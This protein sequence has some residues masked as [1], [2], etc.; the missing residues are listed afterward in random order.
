MENDL[1]KNEIKLIKAMLIVFFIVKGV[2]LEE[3]VPHGTTVNE[4]YYKK[5]LAKLR[6]RVKKNKQT[7]QYWKNSFILHW[8]NATALTA[9]FV[10]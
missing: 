2:I 7:N 10:K 9:L 8:D 3:L 4:H 5:V 1:H 6:K